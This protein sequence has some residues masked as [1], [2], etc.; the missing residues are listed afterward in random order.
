MKTKTS[1]ECNH[2]GFCCIDPVTQINL[3][4][5]DIKFIS[6][7][8]RFSIKSLFDKQIISF[9]PFIK[10]DDFSLFD[11]ELGLDKPCSLYKDNKC[12]I[13]D[14]RPM[15]CRTFPIWLINNKIKDKDLKCIQ[16]IILDKITS[17]RY[18]EYERIV[19]TILLTESEKTDQFMRKMEIYQKIDISND[20]IYKGLK[21]KLDESKNKKQTLRI[22]AKIIDIAKKQVDNKLYDKINLIEHEIKNNDYD[23]LIDRLA[24]A[25]VLIDGAYT[26]ISFK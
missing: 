18:K 7:Y 15:N 26:N 5:L 4:F 13:Y 20:P 10:N 24:G 3:T 22:I 16:N 1:F 9:V 17:I 19:G 6:D 8:T 12:C 14:A 11:V 21:Q 2:C 23:Y 25:E